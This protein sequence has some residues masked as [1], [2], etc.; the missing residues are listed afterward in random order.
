MAGAWAVAL[1]LGAWVAPGFAASGN[2]ENQ[3]PRDEAASSAKQAANRYLR[4]G[5]DLDLDRAE[6]ALCDDASPEVTPSDLD[7]IRQSYDDEMGGITR[8]DLTT[9]EPVAGTDGTT[10]A[11]TVSYVSD[12]RP[13][14]ED[15]VV[16]VQERDGGY[17]VSNAVRVESEEPSSDDS[18]GEAVDPKALA[19]DFMRATVVDREPTTAAALQCDSYASTTPQEIDAAITEWAATNG[20][21]TAFLAAVNPAESSETSV[22]T[23]DVEITLDAGLNQ[24]SFVFAVGVQDDCVASLTGGDGLI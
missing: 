7:A 2:P 13:S 24:E 15:F 9:G 20:E 5:S 4:W 12:A 19:T 10:V 22:T 17:C 3:D 21:T 6:A 23:Y 1:M 16:T 11:A 8:I 18:T 14:Y